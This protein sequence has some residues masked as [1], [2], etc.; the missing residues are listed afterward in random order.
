MRKITPPPKKKNPDIDPHLVS[1]FLNMD[2]SSLMSSAC[3]LTLIV[4][5]A[6]IAQNKQ[7]ILCT[8]TSVTLT[9]GMVV[10]AR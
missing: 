3:V 10:S 2:Y 1:C 5:H 4:I 9:N 8:L 6:W 7:L